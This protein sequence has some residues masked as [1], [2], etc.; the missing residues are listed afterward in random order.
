MVKL[1]SRAWEF[2]MPLEG[3]IGG[4]L[5]P[6][7][8][9][10]LALGLKM[11]VLQ[12]GYRH[13]SVH[14]A[15]AMIVNDA[16]KVKAIKGKVVLVFRAQVMIVNDTL[17]VKTMR[18]FVCV[19]DTLTVPNRLYVCDLCGGCTPQSSCGTAQNSKFFSFLKQQMDKHLWYNDNGENETVEST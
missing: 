6:S 18:R 10:F 4:W 7:A 16:P 19:W 8:L 15:Q 9:C 2:G 1:A 5:G 12:L 3:R 17:K 14:F 13:L 11:T